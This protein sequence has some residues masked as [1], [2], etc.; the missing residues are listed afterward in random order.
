MQRKR[1]SGP[2]VPAATLLRYTAVNAQ[3]ADDGASPCYYRK[4]LYQQ[5]GLGPTFSLQ[6][7]VLLAECRTSA[8]DSLLPPQP[9]ETA[10]PLRRSCCR[11]LPAKFC[12]RGRGG[13]RRRLRPWHQSSPQ[14]TVCEAVPAWDMHSCSYPGFWPTAKPTLR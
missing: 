4:K 3:R 11:S 13:T 14:K 10:P 12:L 6:S 9:S 2:S 1:R 7:I 8:R 5:V